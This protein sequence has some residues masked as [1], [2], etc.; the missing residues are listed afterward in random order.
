[1]SSQWN[2]RDVLKGLAVAS[3]AMIVPAKLGAASEGERAS[4]QS[5]ELHV[6]PV[7]LHTFRLSIFPVEKDGSRPLQLLVRHAE[8]PSRRR[9]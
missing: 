2:R 9:P 7:S 6:T 1:M 3:T 8:P 4:A 5:I